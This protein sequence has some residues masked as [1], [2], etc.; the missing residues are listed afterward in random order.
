MLQIDLTF[1]GR[2]KLT[3]LSAC[4]AQLVH[5][6]QLLAQANGRLESE[7]GF[8]RNQLCDAQAQQV[9]KDRDAQSLMLQVHALQC[10]ILSKTVPHESDVVKKKLVRTVHKF[11]NK[12]QAFFFICHVYLF[13]KRVDSCIQTCIRLFVY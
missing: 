12:K 3:T 10:Q 4:F 11:L 6:V 5:K 1:E 13:N 9:A 7:I 8:L 2:H